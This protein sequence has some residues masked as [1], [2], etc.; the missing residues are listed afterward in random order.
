[1]LITELIAL[2]YKRYYCLWENE[3]ESGGGGVRGGNKV[4]Y[5]K[6]SRKNTIA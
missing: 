4:Y 5:G 6:K 3:N 1:M 2:F